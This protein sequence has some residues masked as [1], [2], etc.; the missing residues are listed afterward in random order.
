[1]DLSNNKDTHD[2][3]FLRKLRA[4]GFTTKCSESG[5]VILVRDEFL[6]LRS[7]S[8]ADRRK[9]LFVIPGGRND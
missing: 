5:S 2:D 3:E 7:E 9:R 1:M 6:Q 8:I 4:L